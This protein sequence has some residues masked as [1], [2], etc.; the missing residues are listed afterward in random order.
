MGS[1]FA[2]GYDLFAAVTGSAIFNGAGSLTAYSVIR[3]VNSAAFAGAGLLN[4]ASVIYAVDTASFAGAGSLTAA[5]VIRALGGSIFAGAGLLSAVGVAHLADAVAFNGVGILYADGVLPAFSGS[6]FFNGRGL[7]YADGY[8][9]IPIPPPIRP[10]GPPFYPV[11]LPYV[12]TNGSG[13]G[14]PPTTSPATKVY[15]NQIATMLLPLPQNYN[16]YPGVDIPQASTLTFIKPDGS[17]YYVVGSFDTSYFFYQG[18]L[19]GKPF[20]VYNVG[21]GEFDQSGWWLVSY[22]S[23]FGYNGQQAAFYVN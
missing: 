14:N 2:D 1:L 12:L 4:A 17:L 19:Y 6:A 13:L 10:P 23:G 7:L 5:A 16:E 15:T 3:A 8:V 9:A 11:G 22:N 21:V 20:V 18:V